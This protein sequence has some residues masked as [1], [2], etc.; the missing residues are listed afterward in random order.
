MMDTPAERKVADGFEVLRDNSRPSQWLGLDIMNHSVFAVK[1]LLTFLIASMRTKHMKN[2]AIWVTSLHFAMMYNFSAKEH[3]PLLILLENLPWSLL[4]HFVTR[5]R[6]YTKSRMTHHQSAVLDKLLKCALWYGGEDLVRELLLDV[7]LSAL[8][9][10]IHGSRAFGDNRAQQQ[11]GG[12]TCLHAA[13]R[14]NDLEMVKVILSWLKFAHGRKA[15]SLVMDAHKLNVVYLAI[16]MKNI[17]V[18]ALMMR[19]RIDIKSAVGPTDP[20][21]HRVAL[22]KL[23]ACEKDRTWNHVVGE[24]IK[25]YESISRKHIEKGDFLDIPVSCR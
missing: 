5:V 22:D 2:A 9:Y 14:A 8:N 23:L 3:S 19:Y 17:E 20:H 15:V 4:V 16:V 7:D 1:N 21:T 12:G 10:L 6:P 25:G 11:E 24:L 18:L 13:I